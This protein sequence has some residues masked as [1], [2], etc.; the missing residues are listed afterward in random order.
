[1]TNRVQGYVLLQ[2]P[3]NST[4]EAALPPCDPVFA[5]AASEQELRY[6]HDVESLQRKENL[7][8]RQEVGD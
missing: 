2:N 3:G 4:S 6:K 5:P 7:L 8:V 1:M